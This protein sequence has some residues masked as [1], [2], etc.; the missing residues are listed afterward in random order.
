MTKTKGIAAAIAVLLLLAI[1]QTIDA[2]WNIESHRT[3]HPGKVIE[4]QELDCW[5]DT[6]CAAPGHTIQEDEPG[7]NCLTMGNHS[8]GPEWTPFWGDIY[9]LDPNAPHENCLVRIGDTSTVVCPD[10]YT[11]SS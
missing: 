4:K 11:T 10:G 8:C 2:R 5:D 9:D 3:T 6:S 7:W 1:G